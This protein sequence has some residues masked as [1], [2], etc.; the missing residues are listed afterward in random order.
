MV[1]KPVLALRWVLSQSVLLTF[2]KIS[3][4]QVSNTSLRDGNLNLSSIYCL[5]HPSIILTAV[6]VK[7][8]G[9]ASAGAVTGFEAGYTL[10]T[11]P[12]YHRADI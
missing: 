11:S 10:N 12:V 5:I 8:F 6:P 4:A 1:Q 7:C 9:G 3:A 2:W